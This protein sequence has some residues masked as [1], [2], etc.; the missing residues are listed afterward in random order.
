MIHRPQ[1]A[2]PLFSSDD[3]GVEDMEPQQRQMLPNFLDYRPALLEPQ[4]LL[5]RP[6]GAQDAHGKAHTNY[7]H[8]AGIKGHRLV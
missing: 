2:K 7:V 5:S 3:N 6:Q 1:Q 8:H 4:Y